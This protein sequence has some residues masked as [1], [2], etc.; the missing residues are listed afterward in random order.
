VEFD[1]FLRAV[2][3][4]GYTGPIEVEV[5]NAELWARP[6]DEIL[7]DTIAAYRKVTAS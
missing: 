7:R 6:G 3:D 2:D 4:A 5:F 1:R